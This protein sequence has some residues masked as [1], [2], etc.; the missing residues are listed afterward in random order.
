MMKLSDKFPIMQDPIGQVVKD[1]FIQP[2]LLSG[3]GDI[4]QGQF[5]QPLYPSYDETGKKIDAKFGTKAFYAGR[6]VAETVVPGSLAYLG[7][8]NGLAD[9]SP[10]AV[11]WLPSY[12]ARNLANATQG[13]SSIGAGAKEDAVRKTLRSILGRTGIPAYTL[14]PTKTSSQ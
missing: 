5:G 8:L 2:W 11:D 3:S 6:S 10:E 9:M 7:I 13:R 12:G 1:Y 14:D 4:A